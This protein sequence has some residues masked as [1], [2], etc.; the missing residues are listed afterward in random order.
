MTRRDGRTVFWSHQTLGGTECGPIGLPLT[1]K[2]GF[3]FISCHDKIKSLVL[4][5]L[6][7]DGEKNPTRCGVNVGNRGGHWSTT[8]SG[9][10]V[11]TLWDLSVSRTNEDTALLL[12]N[13]AIA[14][15]QRL[16]DYKVATEVK[17]D[18]TVSCGT[19]ELII[20]VY[21]AGVELNKI[22]ITRTP[23]Q[24]GWIWQ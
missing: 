13:T 10:S 21:G 14:S 12:K 4:N 22:L 5:I 11:G 24:N 15:L 19:F 7:T 6:F 3:S 18:V 20:Y 9:R 8:F 2:G 16:I 23:L 1:R 17:V